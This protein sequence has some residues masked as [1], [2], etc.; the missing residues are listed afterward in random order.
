MSTPWCEEV[1]M[2]ITLLDLSQVEH[3]SHG[4]PAQTVGPQPN[5]SSALA[6][7][8]G[9]HDSSL[10]R[11]KHRLHLS[12]LC[13]ARHIVIWALGCLTMGYFIGSPE[14]MSALGWAHTLPASDGP[15][16]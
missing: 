14:E 13:I 2:S 8:A 4:T 3:S 7:W 9:A 1:W 15:I 12:W 6:V 10:W 16:G 11:V 5:S